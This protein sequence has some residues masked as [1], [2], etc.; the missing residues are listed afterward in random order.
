MLELLYVDKY[1]NFAYNIDTELET[2]S[3]NEEG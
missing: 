2:E 1:K 3:K